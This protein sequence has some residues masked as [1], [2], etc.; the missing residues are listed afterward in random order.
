MSSTM[1]PRAAIEWGRLAAA[2]L[3]L[4]GALGAAQAQCKYKR[5]GAI[6]ATWVGSR[7]TIDGSINDKPMKMVV[8]TGAVWTTL[9]GKLAQRLEL[10]LVHAD[11]SEL[12]FGG[13]SQISLARLDEMSVGPFRFHKTRAAVA[14]NTGD[15]IP[16]VLVGGNLL[17]QNDVELD[18]K[19]III[20][21]PSGCG[22]AE[23]GYWDDG[24]PWVPTEAV[25][26]DDL[27]TT[28]VVQVNGR[29]VRA[30]IDTG[31]PSTM[32]DEG[33]AR[34]LGLD[35]DAARV[36]EVGGIGAHRQALSAVTFDTIA[37]GPEVIHRPRILVSRL[38]QGV[39]DDRHR[40]DTER[41]VDEQQQMILGAD[42]VRSHRLLFATSQR[43]LY[44][45]YLG[46]EVFRAP[47]VR[48]AI[49]A[50]AA[51]ASDATGAAAKPAA[52]G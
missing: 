44:F 36:G 47:A 29:P 46:G 17:L 40:M 33:V 38:W 9:S 3:L 50:P 21:S 25:T 32:L 4:A 15:G 34:S 31:A 35:P 7:L 2:A 16:D 49:V 18:G 28:I 42:F 37:I 27:R 45:S 22:D 52:G 24:V 51:A 23:L 41:Y 11:G 30:L 10:T 8:D 12:G 26:D 1:A 43:R 48:P 20:F 5:I 39:K 19:Q 13:E 6:P 14:W